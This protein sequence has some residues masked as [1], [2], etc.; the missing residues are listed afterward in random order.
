LDV[1]HNQAV[2]QRHGIMSI[3]TLL[4]FEQGELVG[5]QVGALPKAALENQIKEHGLV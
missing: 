1:D 5:T 2:A 3:P 4:F